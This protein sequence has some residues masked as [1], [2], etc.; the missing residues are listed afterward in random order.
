[1]SSDATKELL[2]GLPG[3]ELILQGLDDLAEG[4][5]T[6]PALLVATGAPR[7]SESIPE[8]GAV[9][10]PERPERRLYAL[11]RSRYPREAYGQY[12]AFLR[13]LTRFCRALES[14][15]LATRAQT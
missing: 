13:R 12:N 1:M 4:G 11:L 15:A 5:D 9:D 14:R 2:Q 6:I 7:L 8:L 3:A 10:L